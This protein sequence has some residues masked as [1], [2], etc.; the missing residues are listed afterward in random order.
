M[1]SLR[2]ITLGCR[3]NSAESEVMKAWAIEQKLDNAII[4]NTCAVTTHAERQARQ[5][6]SP[7]AQR[8]SWGPYY[9]DRMCCTTKS[10]MK[11][12]D[13]VIGNGIMSSPESFSRDFDKRLDVG[14]I[15]L[16]TTQERGLVIH[17]Q[18]SPKLLF[19]YKTGATIFVPFAPFLLHADGARVFLSILRVF[20]QT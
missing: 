12:I 1:V 9:C 20:T 14:P 11:E 13:R 10:S 15:S 7:P 4:V 2:V 19:K 6:N 16:S 18:G 8:K 17:V 5:T 3:R